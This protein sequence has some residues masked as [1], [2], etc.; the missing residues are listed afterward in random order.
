MV[1]SD[2]QF[3]GPGA[4]ANFISNAVVYEPSTSTIFI[5]G[6]MQYIYAFGGPKSAAIVYEIKASIVEGRP[7]VEALS[8][9][10]GTEIHTKEWKL[11]NPDWNK[12]APT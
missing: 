8:N 3:S 12:K 5:Q 11:A 7:I 1:S 10:P 2:P 6:E 9:Y 4:S